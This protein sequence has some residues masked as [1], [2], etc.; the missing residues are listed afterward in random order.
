MIDNCHDLIYPKSE[1]QWYN[2]KLLHL[3]QDG[4]RKHKNKT[5]YIWCIFLVHTTVVLIIPRIGDTE[6]K[7]RKKGRNY[8]TL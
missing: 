2:S 8:C 7:T 5:N 3:P 6:K 1:I 4:K